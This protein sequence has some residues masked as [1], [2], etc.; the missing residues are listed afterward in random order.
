[1]DDTRLRDASS[2]TP[3]PRSRATAEPSRDTRRAL[4]V[5]RDVIVIS[6]DEEDREEKE[7]SKRAR[8]T[9]TR[10]GTSRGYRRRRL[11]RRRH[12]LR[13]RRLLHRRRHRL[14]AAAFF[15]LH[16]RLLARRHPRRRSGLPSRRELV[17][18]HGSRL[19]NL[20]HAGTFHPVPDGDR[21]AR[22]R[23]RRRVRPRAEARG[24]R[25]SRETR[26]GSWPRRGRLRV[27]RR[28]SRDR[29]GS[30]SGSRGWRRTRTDGRTSG[31]STLR[32][33]PRGRTTRGARRAGRRSTASATRR[34][35]ARRDNRRR[36]TRRRR[37]ARRTPSRK[38]L[39]IAARR[40]AIP[41]GSPPRRRAEGRACVDG[42]RRDGDA[43]TYA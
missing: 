16:S 43:E 31:A 30:P 7:G 26:V 24:G 38:N 11:L 28:P 3:T 5:D 41:T 21:G 12:L 27:P 13:R 35:R 18:S 1:M 20:V 19:E 40:R 6:D 33:T 39:K 15:C 22:R 37:R 2:T 9:K 10:R 29:G 34:R 14:A 42:S 8:G 25:S 17:R 32:K 4:A 36:T 23:Q